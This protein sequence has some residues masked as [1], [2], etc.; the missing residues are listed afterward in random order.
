MVNTTFRILVI[1]DPSQYW[2]YCQYRQTV[3]RNNIRIFLLLNL[4]ILL[5]VF[6]PILLTQHALLAGTQQVTSLRI[7]VPS[8]HR[9]LCFVYWEY[10]LALAVKRDTEQC[11]L[12]RD[13]VHKTQEKNVLFFCLIYEII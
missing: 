13:T 5:F 6:Y 8:Q 12:H 11:T 1:L 2:I 10:Q 9:V 4:N 7:A 3:V